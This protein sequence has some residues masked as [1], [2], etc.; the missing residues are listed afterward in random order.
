MEIVAGDDFDLLQNIC[1][2]DYLQKESIL[3]A[4]VYRAILIGFNCV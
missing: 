4:Y 3:G 1:N 2:R